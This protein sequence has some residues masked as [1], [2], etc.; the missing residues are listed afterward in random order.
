VSD[1]QFSYLP[2]V[3]AAQWLRARG[4]PIAGESTLRMMRD[5]G[6]GPV[7]TKIPGRCLYH[8]EDLENWLQEIGRNNGHKGGTH[9]F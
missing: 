3:Q 7:C 9:V 2:T 5:R 1:R 4:A 6:A 8:I